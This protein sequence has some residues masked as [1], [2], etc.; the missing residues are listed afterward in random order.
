MWFPNLLLTP[1]FSSIWKISPSL[2]Q[3]IPFCYKVRCRIPPWTNKAIFYCKLYLTK[4]YMKKHE[5]QQTLN[6]TAALPNPVIPNRGTQHT[7]VLQNIELL[8]S[9]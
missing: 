8:P 7:I 4:D 6:N 2:F 5:L 9:T 3:N 1:K